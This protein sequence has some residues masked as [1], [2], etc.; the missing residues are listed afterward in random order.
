MH[1]MVQSDV[2][3]SRAM[4]VE[5]NLYKETLKMAQTSVQWLDFPPWQ[6][7]SSQG[8][9]C[10]AVCGPEIDYWNGAPT[11]LPC[12]GSEWL[13]AVSKNKVCLKGTMISGYWRHPKNV[14]A[15]LKAIPEQEFEKK[16]FQPWL[17]SKSEWSYTPTSPLSLH[18]VVLRAQGQLYLQKQHCWAKWHSCPWGVLLRWPSSISCIQLRLQ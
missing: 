12:F 5:L 10:Q 17:R 11:L 9:L 3:S 4:Y 1:N 6:C 16:Y 7:S 14:T 8:A 15:G 2:L 18:G 13:L